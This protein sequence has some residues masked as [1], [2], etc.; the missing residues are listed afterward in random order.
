MV[1]KV[2]QRIFWVDTSFLYALFVASDQNHGAATRV[3]REF[4][5]SRM[6][7]VISPFILSELGTLLAYRFS[8]A[9]ALEQ[10]AAVFD[11]SILRCV[12]PDAKIIGDAMEWWR[13]FKDKRFSFADCVSFECMRTL[14]IRTALSFDGDFAVA[15]FGRVGSEGEWE[16]LGI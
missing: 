13:R 8:H 4:C 9:V 7:G 14:N 5:T 11:S 1:L 10:T 6:T 2:D 16:M 12:Y 15:G 3:W